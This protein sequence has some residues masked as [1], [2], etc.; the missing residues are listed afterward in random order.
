M[1]LTKL[2]TSKP[3]AHCPFR[4]DVRPYIRTSRV[5][6]IWEAA[7]RGDHFVCHETVDYDLPADAPDPGRRACAGFLIVARRDGLLNGLTYVQLAERLARVSF[8]K[9]NGREYVY[10]S[11]ADMIAA[12]ERGESHGRT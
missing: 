3:C 7:K 4:N 12:H 10:R 6:E 11:A 1:K 9:L 5:R 8:S 2:A